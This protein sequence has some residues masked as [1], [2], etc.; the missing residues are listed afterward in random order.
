MLSG[1]AKRKKK[2]NEEEQ[3]KRQRGALQKFLSGSRPTAVN[4]LR[5][6]PGDTARR[7]GGR[8][9]GK[10]G[11]CAVNIS[12]V[13]ERQTDGRT[14][15]KVWHNVCFP[16]GIVAAYSL[17]GLHGKLPRMAGGHNILPLHQHP[18]TVGNCEGRKWPT[19]SATFGE[20]PSTLW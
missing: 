17:D 19:A 20:T 13:T 11:A 7:R 12:A 18:H 4:L 1:A 15:H 5:A 8:C 16:R 6:R 14:V 10:C 2:K 3:K 9:D